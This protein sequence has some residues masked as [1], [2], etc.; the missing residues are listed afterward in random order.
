[1]SSYLQIQYSRERVPKTRFPDDLVQWLRRKYRIRWDAFVLDVGCGRGDFLDAWRR[2]GHAVMGVDRE[3][4]RAEIVRLDI[5]RRSL[6]LEPNKVDLVFSK[7]LIEHLADPRRMLAEAQRV[8]KPGGRIIVL[9]P[10][11]RTY[12]RTFYDDYTHVRPY[13][14]V[15]LADL[16]LAAGFRCVEVERIYQYPPLWDWPALR[17]LAWLWRQLAPVELSLWLSSCTGCGFFRWASQLTLLGSGVKP[18]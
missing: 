16:L 12:M 6:P 3:P 14:Q 7:S 4:V 5:S 18:L 17:P 9:T 13:D 2:M 1:M 11:W 15:S 10:D 8:L